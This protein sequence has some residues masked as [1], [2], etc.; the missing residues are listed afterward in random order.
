MLTSR[1]L[2]PPCNLPLPPSED[3]G[4]GKKRKDLAF[5]RI[6]EVVAAI[7]IILYLVMALLTDATI[8]SLVSRAGS[9]I[10]APILMICRHL[11]VEV[12]RHHS[13]ECRPSVALCRH[14]VVVIHLCE[15]R[16]RLHIA[17]S[18]RRH[19]GMCPR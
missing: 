7:D 8:L 1:A 11:D 2:R 14:H 10:A 4:R 6:I 19:E 9:I 15:E 12:S 18:H 3:E 16:C 17:I 13:E 5:S